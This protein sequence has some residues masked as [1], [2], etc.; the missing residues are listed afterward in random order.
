[1]CRFT[2]FLCQ[3]RQLGQHPLEQWTTLLKSRQ[4]VRLYLV[5]EFGQPQLIHRYKVKGYPEIKIHID[6]AWA[7]M[8][9]VCPEFREMCYLKEINEIADSFCTNFHKV[10]T[11]L[12]ECLYSHI[13][14]RVVGTDQLRCMPYV[15]QRSKVPNWRFGYYSSVLA[16][17]ARGCWWM[18]IWIGHSS[19][20]NY[21]VRFRNGRRLP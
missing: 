5:D 2:H 19:E 16:H 6:A 17:G 11:S 13:C 7:G 12:S 18:I 15:G 20:L 1:M 4:L 14:L 10:R 8:A 3:S 9:L 21:F